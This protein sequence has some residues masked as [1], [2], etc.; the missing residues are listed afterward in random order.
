MSQPFF[1]FSIPHVFF[2]YFSL[3][4]FSKVFS[5]CI[6]FLIMIIF[7]N[8]LILMINRN[9]MIHTI[10]KLWCRITYIFFIIFTFIRIKYSFENQSYIKLFFKVQFET[11]WLYFS[12][13][14]YCIKIF[15][16]P[17]LFFI[18]PILN[19][20]HTNDVKFFSAALFST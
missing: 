3:I 16:S 10:I 4:F 8:N 11:N 12:F 1:T 14:L 6:S 9:F 2:M 7:R 20:I 5:L 15:E 19:L 13:F 17:W 18:F